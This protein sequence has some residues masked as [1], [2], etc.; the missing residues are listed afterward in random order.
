MNAQTFGC[1][2]EGDAVARE[3]EQMTAEALTRLADA[4]EA[5]PPASW[6]HASMCEAWHVRDVVAHMTTAARYYGAAFMAEVAAHGGDLNRTVDALAARDGR[7]DPA[8]LIACLR[9]E[10]LHRWTPPGGGAEGALLHAVVHGFDVALPLGLDL[11]V[12]ADPGVAVLEMLTDGGIHARF[13][14]VIEGIEL[15]VTD[16][17]WSWGHGRLVTGD[18]AT[19]TL[20]LCGRAVGLLAL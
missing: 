16:L 17:D 20:A 1:G 8:T 19:I 13:G 5:Q 2:S 7:L 15:A 12:P 6:D 3:L 10:T 14:T 4:L 18:A 11:G 9:D